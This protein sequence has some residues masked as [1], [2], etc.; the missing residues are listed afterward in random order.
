ME[1]EN[2]YNGGA[3]IKDKISSSSLKAL[4][5]HKYTKTLIIMKEGP[6][7]LKEK[8]DKYALFS[9]IFLSTIVPSASICATQ[10]TYNTCEYKKQCERY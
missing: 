1:K 2:I 7:C 6:G 9:K 8:S 10:R 4:V 5:Y 3:W